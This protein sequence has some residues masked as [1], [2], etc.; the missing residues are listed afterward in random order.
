M[1]SEFGSIEATQVPRDQLVDPGPALDPLPGPIPSFQDLTDSSGDERDGDDDDWEAIVRAA[2]EAFT[3]QQISDMTH[4]LKERGLFAFVSEYV[5][6]RAIPIRTLLLAFGLMIPLDTPFPDQ[7]RMLKV[8]CSRVLRNRERLEQYQT[9]DDAV[10]LIRTSKKILVLTGAGV[11]TSCGIPDFRSPTGLYARLKAQGTWEL[12]DPQDMFDLR[13]FKERPDV[14]YSFAKEIYPS[15]F[16]PSPCHRFVRLLELNDKLLRNYTQNIDG[17]FEQVGVER[18]LNC[19]GS[20]ASASCLNCRT[21]YPGSFIESDVFASRVPLCPACTQAAAAAFA[22]EKK[23]QLDSTTPPI[24]KKRK[25][26]NEWERDDNDDDDEDGTGG[27]GLYGYGN[28]WRDKAIIKPDIVFFG[29]NL[30]DEFDRKLL[31]DRDQ[32]D[33]LIVMGTSL[34]VSPVAQLPSHLPHSIPQILINRDPVSHHNFDLCLLGDGDT[35][36]EYLCRRLVEQQQQQENAE[37]RLGGTCMSASS[38]SSSTVT[39]ATPPTTTTT[40]AAPVTTSKRGRQEEEEEEERERRGGQGQG[41]GSEWSLN[42]R[43]PVTRPTARKDRMSSSSSTSRVDEGQPEHGSSAP[44][45]ERRVGP[46]AEPVE[47]DENEEKTSRFDR[48]VNGDR[49]ESSTTVDT[50]TTTATAEEKDEEQVVPERVSTSHVW[51]FPGSDRDHRWTKLVREA[52][53]DDRDVDDDDDDED[54]STDENEPER[55]VTVAEDEDDRARVNNDDD[56]DEGAR[57]RG[58]TRPI[59]NGE[60]QLEGTVEGFVELA[61]DLAPG[62]VAGAGSD[63]E[64]EEEEEEGSA[65][66]DES[67]D[68][69]EVKPSNV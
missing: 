17:L 50:T 30:S 35:I 45:L 51:L 69:T 14:F 20:F 43:V 26:V 65:E 4:F 32:V 22:A 46:I 27:E 2:E 5:D 33:L 1:A 67:E 42:E 10:E 6:R 3:E 54:E 25:L 16:I 64:E 21:T 24:K 15:N 60:R 36:V 63:G 12:D 34:R 53:D 62:V 47:E 58:G 39:T 11:S 38:S 49:N 44:P 13:F 66:D 68:G 59:G 55:G 52:Y 29:E 48:A 56:D 61:A 41:S 8:A 28:G 7:L 19:H 37:V 23:K 57:R 40:A 18:M 31:A 9:I